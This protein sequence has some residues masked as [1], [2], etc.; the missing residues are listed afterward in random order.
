MSKH[1]N[2]LQKRLNQL[3]D[4]T[5]QATPLWGMM[6]PQHMIEHLGMIIYG[7]AH[8]KGQKLV[9]PDEEAAKWKQRFF[10]SYYPFPRNIPMAGT[11]NQPPSLN[12]LRYVSLDEAK[13]KLSSAVGLFLNNTAEDPSLGAI[14]GYFGP[15]TGEEW[16]AFHIKHVEHHL[17]QFDLM[18]HDEKIPVLEK[19]L[20]KVKKYV[21]VEAQAKFGQM[22]AHQMVEH[23]GLV[24]LL[25]T[26][27]FDVKYEGTVDQA[28]K[29]R[30]QFA[31]S[32]QPWIDVFPIF[33]FGPPKLPRHDTI[34]S[35]KAALFK[36]FQ[37]YLTFCEDQPEAIVPH[38]YLGDLSVDQ[39]RQ[40]HVKH[41]RHHLRQFG[42][43]V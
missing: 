41:V 9:I 38:Y 4:I 1:I 33:A 24:F 27:K 15:L 39:W 6:T 14:H 3:L 20:H 34:E 2:K 30:A 22:N 42:V 26:G 40:V 21:E 7:T 31:A 17:M 29:Y 28:E 16:L 13:D 23:L 5:E 37:N 10:S 32:D 36:T 35:S 8:G 25:S 12:E 11:Q 18:P 19:L 43:E